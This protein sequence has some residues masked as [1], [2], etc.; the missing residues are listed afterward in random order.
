M[1]VYALRS[2]PD[3][4]YAIVPPVAR[5]P[6][7]PDPVSDASEIDLFAEKAVRHKHLLFGFRVGDSFLG[8]FGIW[9]DRRSRYFL[10]LKSCEALI[11]IAK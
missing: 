9:A 6:P 11:E 3:G 8:Y 10:G 2:S 1:L 5:T 7:T 4:C